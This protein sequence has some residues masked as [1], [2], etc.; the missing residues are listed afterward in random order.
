MTNS[1][2]GEEDYAT[3]RG[4]VTSSVKVSGEAITQQLDSRRLFRLLCGGALSIAAGNIFVIIIYLDLF[5]EYRREA[6]D[7]RYCSTHQKNSR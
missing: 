2:E 3:T 5:T 7:N 4:C 1:F 6:S